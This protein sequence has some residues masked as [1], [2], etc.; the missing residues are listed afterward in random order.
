MKLLTLL[1]LAILFEF[2]LIFPF[3]KAFD[4]TGTIILP[5]AQ[6]NSFQCAVID[7]T[8]TNAYFG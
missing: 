6:W 2:A 8:G 7:S 4:E 3:S 1:E 5:A